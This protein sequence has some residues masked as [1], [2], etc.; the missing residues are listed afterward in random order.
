M[1]LKGNAKVLLL[2][3]RGI[4]RMYFHSFIHSFMAMP[5]G[6]QKF[7]GARDRTSATAVTQ[8]TAVTMQDP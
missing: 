4:V 3:C 6:M 7:P 2:S 1:N 8:A 5:C